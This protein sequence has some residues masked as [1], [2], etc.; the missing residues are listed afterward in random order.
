LFL[1]ETFH[2]FQN[3]LK[4]AEKRRRLQVPSAN[5]AL[6]FSQHF[7]SLVTDRPS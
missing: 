3:T 1:K 5:H 6:T 2:R 4:T 7:A